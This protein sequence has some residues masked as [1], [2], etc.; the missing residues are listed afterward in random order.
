M[1]APGSARSGSCRGCCRGLRAAF[2]RARLRVRLDGGF[3]AAPLFA[4]LERERLE[5]VVA[6]GKNKVL[7]A[8][9]RAFDGHRPA[10]V[11]RVGRDR[12]SV[13]RDPLC[14]RHLG[15]APPC[16]HQGRGGASS[17]GVNP[18]TTL[19]SSSPTSNTRRGICTRRSTAPEA[20][21][22]TGSKSCTMGWKSTAPVAVASSPTNCAGFLSATA[23]VLYQELRLRAAR[24]AFRV[25]SGQHSARTS[26]ETRRLGRSPPCGVSCCILP[27]TCLHRNDWQIIAR[28][29]GAAPA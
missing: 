14:R 9:R 26:H 28:H 22:K 23:Y 19:A 29:L 21:S 16:R 25:R 27:A 8:P 2:P 5:Y 11:A 24:T 10:I 1:P 7:Q 13:Q 4:F 17:L 6:M 3:A 15:S 20:T 18:K 12:T